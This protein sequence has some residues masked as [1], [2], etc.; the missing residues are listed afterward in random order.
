MVQGDR[1]DEEAHRPVGLRRCGAR[2]QHRRSVGA[3][4]RRGDD[5]TW[6]VAQTTEGVVVVEVPP[7]ALLVGVTGDAHDHR[8]D[9]LPGGEE[10]QRRCL[11]TELVDGVVHVGE[12]L[13]LRDR[14]HP[15]EAGAE[16]ESE[17]RLLVEH[18][19]EHAV[20]PR[21]PLEAAGDAVH[22]ALG[23]DVLT[24]HEHRRIGG[25][26]L[27][28]RAVDRLGE[29]QRRAV[30]R[31]RPEEPGPPCRWSG[32]GDPV[33][34]Q[35][36]TAPSQRLDDLLGAGQ[37]PAAHQFGGLGADDDAR[38]E[39]ATHQLRWRRQSAGDEQT[40]RGDDRVSQAIGADAARIA[41]GGLDVRPGV[42]AE[43]HDPQ[44]EDRRASILAD[45]LGE[46]LGCL[47]DADRIRSVDEQ[48]GQPRSG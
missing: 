46:L 34:D 32:D 43:A 27:G 1:L 14:Q 22:T 9:V 41:I 11:A 44:V 2:T 29:G 40:R 28:E 19:V 18:G 3:A 24:E 37:P 36:G 25:E 45:E 4:R 16:G 21:H 23:A 31:Q 5:D 10:R 13:D 8:V 48:V 33:G 26:Q 35:P 17:D 7:E 42:P 12:V 47:V 30:L 38:V 6:E 20:A 39:D 15:G